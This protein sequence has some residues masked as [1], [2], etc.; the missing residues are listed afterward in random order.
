ML[1]FNYWGVIICIVLMN[2]FKLTE[3]RK[4]FRK[5]IKLVYNPLEA[6]HPIFFYT[7]SWPI[8]ISSNWDTNFIHRNMVWLENQFFIREISFL[9]LLPT[10]SDGYL[11][12]GDWL[13]SINRAKP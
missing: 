8:L 11:E 9:L 2:N 6:M 5:N 1:H 7:L 4:I 13:G 10:Q 12:L 3:A